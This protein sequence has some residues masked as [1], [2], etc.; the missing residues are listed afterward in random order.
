MD[1]RRYASAI[2][3]DAEVFLDEKLYAFLEKETYATEYDRA[4]R[5]LAEMDAG[6]IRILSRSNS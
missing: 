4:L 6:G 2:V 5:Y 3:N 1:A